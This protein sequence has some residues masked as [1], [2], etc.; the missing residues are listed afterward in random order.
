MASPAFFEK[1]VIDLLIAMN[2]GAGADSGKRVGRT[3]DG[4]IDGIINEDALGLDV[5]YIQ[6][7]RY[8]PGH[9]IGIDKIH[10]FAGAMTARHA[11]K[12]VFATTSHFTT[13]AR[14]TADR[15]PY[16]LILI[17]GEELSRLMVRYGV[18][19]RSLRSIEMKKVDLDYFEDEEA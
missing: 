4:G 7:K 9:A 14:T 1:I 8:A 16:R 5:V 3:G 2:Y 6:A 18:G 17:D 11:T 10:E 15:L 13:S 19:V 12:G